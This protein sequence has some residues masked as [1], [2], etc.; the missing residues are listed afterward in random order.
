MGEE[1]ERSTW[2]KKKIREKLW[3]RKEEIVGSI[4]P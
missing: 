2:R 3:R 1:G 4:S